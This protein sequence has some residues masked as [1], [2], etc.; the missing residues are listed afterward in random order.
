MLFPAAAVALFLTASASA[1]D[2]DEYYRLMNPDDP[3]YKDDFCTAC[4]SIFDKMDRVVSGIRPSGSDALVA[5]T[6]V[7]EE[8]CDW[9]VGPTREKC[10]VLVELYENDLEKYI[11]TWEISKPYREDTCKNWCAL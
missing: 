6:V 8:L 3:L 9:T 11:T 10:L 4:N 7:T 1:E 5:A 2:E